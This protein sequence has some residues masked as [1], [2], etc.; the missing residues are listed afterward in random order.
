M[1][2]QVRRQGQPSSSRGG[3]ISSLVT[4]R[5]ERAKLS[6]LLSHA[7]G[8]QGRQLGDVSPEQPR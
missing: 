8:H 7:E 3:P 6:S 5:M 1:K 4:R 2:C